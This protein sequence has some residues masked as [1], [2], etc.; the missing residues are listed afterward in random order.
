[1][2]DEIVVRDRSVAV[3]RIVELDRAEVRKGI[4]PWERAARQDG[5]AS[6]E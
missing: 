2:E 6:H 5:I 1:M 3:E 4:E